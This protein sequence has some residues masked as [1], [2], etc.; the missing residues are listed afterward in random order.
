MISGA[1]VGSVKVMTTDYRGHNPEEIVDLAM[2]KI[3]YVSETAHPVIHQQAVAFR[4]A[5]RQTLTHYIKF[6]QEQE[7][8][9]ICGHLIKGGHADLAN[10]IRSM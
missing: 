5:L 4:D 1:G 3:L 9:T 6:A 2:D 8:I 10:I 7:R